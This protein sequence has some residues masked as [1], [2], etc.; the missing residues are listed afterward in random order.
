[1]PF[2]KISL[3]NNLVAKIEN[4]MKK[5]DRYRSIAEFISEAVRLRIEQLERESPVDYSVAPHAVTMDK[6]KR[7]P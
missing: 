5:I 3:S 2:R 4:I 7:Q 1:M 6:E